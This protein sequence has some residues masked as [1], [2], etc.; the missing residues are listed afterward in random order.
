MISVNV[1][2]R[3]SFI[4]CALLVLFFVMRRIRKSSLEID[5]SIFWL[6]LAAILIVVALFPQLAYAV[7][8]LLGFASPS[9]FIFAC[10]IIVLLVR[11]FTQDQKIAVLKRKLVRMAQHDALRE[12]GVERSS[13]DTADDKHERSDNATAS[14]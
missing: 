9:N 7:S 1:P 6:V 8:D 2:L 4:V 11:T 10:G 12:E 13:D 3:V 5:D 14:R